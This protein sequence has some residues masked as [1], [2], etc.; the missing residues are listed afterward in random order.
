MAA[1]RRWS[2]ARDTPKIR[3]TCRHERHSRCSASACA[4]SRAGTPSRTRLAFARRRPAR[5]SP[6]WFI[7][8]THR[9][10]RHPA[11]AGKRDARGSAHRRCAVR[12]LAPCLGGALRLDAPGS[13]A[14]NR[15]RAGRRRRK[16]C[17]GGAAWEVG[18]CLTAGLRSSGSKAASRRRSMKG[19]AR[20]SRS[21]RH[22]RG[23]ARPQA[24]VRACNDRTPPGVSRGPAQTLRPASKCTCA[25][26]HV[27]A[28]APSHRHCGGRRTRNGVKT[29]RPGCLARL[30]LFRTEGTRAGGS[31]PCSPRGP[32]AATLPRP[33]G[34]CCSQRRCALGGEAEGRWSVALAFASAVPQRRQAP[35]GQP[36]GQ[37][38]VLT[39]CLCG[40]DHIG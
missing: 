27:P 33:R 14:A 17:G 9:G 2:V 29:P 40:R 21:Y 19:A 15:F 6:Y 39:A 28:L 20:S 7:G 1:R 25:V 10:A 31:R 12:T 22:S 34:A 11:S 36:S 30:V 32:G 5:P 35:R 16:S 26:W 24:A 4:S 38:A 3:A 13:R 18:L 37:P 23:T 8:R